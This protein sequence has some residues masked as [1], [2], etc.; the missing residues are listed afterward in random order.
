MT[1]PVKAVVFDLDGTLLDTGTTKSIA[2]CFSNV[3]A[4]HG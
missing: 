2:Q 4:G 3:I 1:R